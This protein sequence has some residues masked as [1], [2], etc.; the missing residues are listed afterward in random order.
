MVID[1]HHHLGETPEDWDRLAAECRRLGI[2]RVVVFGNDAN[3]A[4]ALERHPDLVIGF[5]FFALGS[6]RPEK[7]GEYRR[8]GFRGVKFIKPAAA[9]DD[10]SFYPVYRAMSEAG[11]LGLFHLGIVARRPDDHLRDVDNSR[12]RPIYLDTIAR[13]FPELTVIG[14]HLGN[15]WY[16]EAAMAARWNP[17]LYFDLSGSTLHCKSPRFLG[18]LLWWT[19][20]SRYREP[21]GRHA[22]E[23]IVFGSDVPV[24]EIG[25]VMAD[26]RRVMAELELPGALQGAVFGGTMARLLGL[27]G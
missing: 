23:K 9:Y 6:D 3:T 8:R 15:P 22:W 14:A 21:N 17:N 25:A 5:G 7:I 18:D 11:L 12:H 24:P 20:N 2:D 13:A 4:A 26:Y 10:R 16:E 27:A 19:P 1:M